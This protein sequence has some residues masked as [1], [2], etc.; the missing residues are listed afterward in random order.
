[1]STTLSWVSVPVLSVQSTSIAPKFWMACRCFTMVFCCAMAMAPRARLA[2]TII[3]SISGV[4]PDGDGDGEE[5]GLQPVVLH[6]AIDEEH[7]GRHHEH[8]LDEQP[9][10]AFHAA[11][12]G[13][14]RPFADELFGHRAEVGVVA[15]GQH[16]GLARAADDAAA[17]EQQVRRIEHFRRQALARG[18]LG[19]A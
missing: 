18:R 19:R 9:A 7:G 10:H 1:M 17:H 6:Q 12:E 2:F 4:R 3:G 5:E 11:V 16:D 14:L 8:E 15:G 13:R